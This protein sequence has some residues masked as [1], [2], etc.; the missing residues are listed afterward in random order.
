MKYSINE[1]ESNRIAIMKAIFIVLV[2]LLH[3]YREE[4]TY[5][6]GNIALVPPAWLKWMEYVLSQLI[7]RTAAPGFFLLSAVLLYRKEFVWKENMK[8][9]VR[10]LLIPYLIL[11]SFWILFFFTAQYIDWLDPYLTTAQ[12][13]VQHWGIR[14]WLDAYFG[15]FVDDY[16]AL[17]PMWFLRDL[18]LLN[19]FAVPLKKCVDAFPRLVLILLG[20]LWFVPVPVP[21]IGGMELSGQ[22]FVFFLLGYYV[23]KYDLHMKL[24]DAWQGWHLSLTYVLLLLACVV[25]I[26]LPV[27]Y[28]IRHATILIGILGIVRLSGILDRSRYRDQILVFSS[29]SF[30]IFLFH[31]MGLTIAAKLSGQLF[32]Q[33]AWVQ[34]LEYIGLPVLVILVCM[35][36]CYVLREKLPKVYRLITGERG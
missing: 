34:F 6:G 23:V 15:N 33:T 11:N 30:S 10:T 13:Q 22:S 14:G 3:S 9:K 26:Y 36:F 16:P 21:G 24:V 4:I 5:V 28:T 8:K 17:Y 19:V 27:Q 18:F 1:N 35:V 20:I 12:S 2:V 29:Y 25:S 31:E 7:A 32:P